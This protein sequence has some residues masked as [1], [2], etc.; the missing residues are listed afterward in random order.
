L[1]KSQFRLRKV[2]PFGL[3]AAIIGSSHLLIG[4]ERIVLNRP[5][6]RFIDAMKQRGLPVEAVGDVKQ[7]TC[8]I[9]GYAIAA[10]VMNHEFTVR[11]CSATFVPAALESPRFADWYA[12]TV[13]GIKAAGAASGIRAAARNEL[14]ERDSQTDIGRL[15]TSGH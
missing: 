6:G 8:P 14:N 2:S 10:I 1:K 7:R 13:A 12:R 9:C 15:Q 3:N 5:V 4:L 11:G